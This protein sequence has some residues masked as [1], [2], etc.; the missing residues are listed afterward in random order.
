MPTIVI[1]YAKGVGY[2]LVAFAYYIISILVYSRV[3]AK[4]REASI[5]LLLIPIPFFYTL[6]FVLN[7]LFA[8]GL[9]LLLG[10]GLFA[11]TIVRYQQLEKE[12][13][14]LATWEK[15]VTTYPTALEEYELKYVAKYRVLPKGEKEK[16]L[17]NIMYIDLYLE[18]EWEEEVRTGRLQFNHLAEPEE[19]HITTD[20]IINWQQHP[21]QLIFNPNNPSELKYY[22]TAAIIQES[23]ESLYRRKRQLLAVFSVVMLL[24]IGLIILNLK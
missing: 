9:I 23:L 2:G 11:W 15:I 10:V 16:V 18:Y 5:L 21:L 19:N 17:K 1:G 20:M 6:F 8:G 14:E 7:G 12:E 4:R 13:K 24:G 22:R 3:T